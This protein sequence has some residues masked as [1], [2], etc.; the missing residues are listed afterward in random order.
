MNVFNRV[1]TILLLIAIWLVVVLVAAAPEQAF[2]WGQ[3]LVEGARQAWATA[4]AAQ[5]VWRVSI[6]RA[7]IIAGAT[8]LI[9]LLLWRELRR[10]RK[11]TVRVR[12]QSGGVVAVTTDSVARRLVWH[13][14]QLADVL[15]V[16][17]TVR[18]RRNA[19]DV[20]LDIETTPDVQVPMKTEEVV[21][22]TRE[23]LH[24]Q[25]GLQLRKLKVN[26]RHAPHQEFI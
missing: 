26:V 25:M 16:Y 24:E 5:P 22:A 11:P 12:L 15:A 1:A 6:V 20:V 3:A 17:P 10:P 7:A 13:V 21:A 2:A 19:V 14:S 8:L 9:V 18:T 23:V 4:V